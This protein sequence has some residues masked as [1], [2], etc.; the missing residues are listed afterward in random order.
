MINS[1]WQIT[2]YNGHI[3]PHPV[4]TTALPGRQNKTTEDTPDSSK[5]GKNNKACLN[6]G[7]GN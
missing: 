2:Q 1:Y 5:K 7:E 6:K 3:V 4:V